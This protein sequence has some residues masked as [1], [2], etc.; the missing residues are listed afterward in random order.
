ML[1]CHSNILNLNSPVCAWT[2]F[3]VTQ[4]GTNFGGASPLENIQSYAR[5]Y[6]C[7]TAEASNYCRN[8]GGDRF[9]WCYT[10]DA[11]TRWEYCI[12]ELCEKGDFSGHPNESRIWERSAEILPE[13][14]DAWF[15]H[16]VSFVIL[17][18]LLDLLKEQLHGEHARASLHSPFKQQL[19]KPQNVSVTDIRRT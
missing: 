19:Q 17:L 7:F 15:H 1:F 2:S 4:T 10:A 16:N 8:T 6:L 14:G 18:C 5:E 3:D 9:P 12:I 11:E 13:K